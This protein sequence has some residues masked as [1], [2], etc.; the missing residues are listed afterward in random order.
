MTVRNVLRSNT[1]PRRKHSE[2]TGSLHILEQ[3]LHFW[4]VFSFDHLVTGISAIATPR[5]D[6]VAAQLE[7]MGVELEVIFPA[8]DI[9]H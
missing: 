4:V 6:F 3:P 8:R 2:N 9:R 5:R 7:A 1:G